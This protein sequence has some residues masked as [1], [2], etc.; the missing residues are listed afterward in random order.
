MTKEIKR[1]FAPWIT[2]DL[3]AMMQERNAVQQH[4]KHDREDRDLQEKYKTLKKTG[5]GNPS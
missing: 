5:Q 2:D 1:P 4:L 3:K